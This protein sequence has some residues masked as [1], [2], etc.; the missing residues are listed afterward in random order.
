MGSSGLGKKSMRV[1]TVAP[2]TRLTV[3]AV[4]VVPLLPLGETEL[5]PLVRRL[6]GDPDRVGG[7][8]D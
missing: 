4:P 3:D 1:L 6:A 5:A 8:D 2:V 7:D